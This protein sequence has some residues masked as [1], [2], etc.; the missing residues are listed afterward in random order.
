MR[1][2]RFEWDEANIEHLARHQVIPAEA[3]EVFASR[4]IVYK[5]RN[6]CFIALGQTEEGRFLTV[7]FARKHSFI[8]VVTARDMD[9]KE[10]K[11]FKRKER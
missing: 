3:E 10:R 1:I 7:V 11:L 5:S 6:D 9:E 4:Y 8:R 2:S